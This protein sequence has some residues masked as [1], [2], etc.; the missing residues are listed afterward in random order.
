MIPLL[1]NCMFEEYYFTE[2]KKGCIKQGRSEPKVNSLH[3]QTVSGRCTSCEVRSSEETPRGAGRSTPRSA[4]GEAPRLRSS[5]ASPHS[6]LSSFESPASSLVL[7][8]CLSFSS[9][10]RWSLYV[11]RTLASNRSDNPPKLG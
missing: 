1:S 4:R 10:S 2:P 7:P 9:I 11:L 8:I 3:T 6:C 5:P